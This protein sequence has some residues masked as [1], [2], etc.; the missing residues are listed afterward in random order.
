VPR[1]NSRSFVS[2]AALTLIWGVNWPV[3]KLGVASLPPLYF[4][5]LGIVGGTAVLGVVLAARGVSL[6][7]P[8]AAWARLV[9]LSV[10]NVMVWYAVATLALTRLP[11]G[12][13][14][15]LGFTMPAWAALIGAAFYRERLD[16]QSALGVAAA[17]GGIVLLVSGDWPT[18]TAHPAGVALMLFAAAAWAFGTH[19]L[20]RSALPVDTTALTFWLMAVACPVLLGASAATEAARWR[21]PDATEWFAI[22]YNATLVLAVGNVLWF[23][24]ARTLPPTTAGLASMLIPVVGV[25]SGM[26]ILHEA[27]SARDFGALVLVCI[28]VATAW[29][30]R[31]ALRK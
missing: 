29:I 19:L 23:T 30:P 26:L 2:I 15:I 6:R 8:R 21:M 13:A 1:P 9:M 22:G 4:R 10:P 24:V 12:R 3:L 16:R 25:F 5:S 20:K 11:A 14:A 27:P 17:V 31:A 28:A 7:V 18:F